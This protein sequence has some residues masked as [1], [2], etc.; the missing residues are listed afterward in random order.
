[1][2]KDLNQVLLGILAEQKQVFELEPP[3]S[4]QLNIQP[5]P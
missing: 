1:M 2:E 5:S 4:P 3:A